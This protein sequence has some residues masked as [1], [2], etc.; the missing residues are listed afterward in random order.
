MALFRLLGRGIV[1]KSGFLDC[2][3]GLALL[4]NRN[5]GP[6]MKLAALAIGIA[7]TIFLIVIEAPFEAIVGVLAP[8]LGLAFDV[9]LD[10][11]E[12]IVLPILIACI[13]LPHLV[14]RELVA[15]IRA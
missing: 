8:G 12:I 7:C 10:G 9:L 11:F 1:R 14:P 4:K 13:A 6:L 5:V 3:T 2:R 15:R